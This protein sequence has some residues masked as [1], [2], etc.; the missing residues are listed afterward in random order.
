MVYWRPSSHA[1]PNGA[2]PSEML[3]IDPAGVL[4]E[5]RTE[6]EGQA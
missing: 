6:L 3:A 1:S 2:L 4:Q 5:D